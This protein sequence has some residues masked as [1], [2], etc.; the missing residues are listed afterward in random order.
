MKVDPMLAD[1]RPLPVGGEWLAE[2]KFDGERII[3]IK[4][5][6]K[7]E[8]WTRRGKEVAFK[9]PEV[10]EPLMA[11]QGDYI[12][13]GELTVQGGFTAVLNR[14]TTKPAMINFL[15]VKMPAT[16]HVFDVLS[17]GTTDYRNASLSERKIAL[18]LERTQFRNSVIPVIGTYVKSED[19]IDGL[20]AK[21]LTDGYEGLVIKN[22]ASRYREGARGADWVKM[23]KSDNFDCFVVGATRCTTN[24]FPFGSLILC[25]DGR[26]MGKVGTGF[27]LPTRNAIMA[28]L[29]ENQ[30]D[31][32]SAFV[33]MPNDVFK[34]V[35]ILTKP[36][37]CEIKAQELFKD[38]TPRHPVWV[39]WR[40]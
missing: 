32:Q 13:D 10:A 2:P 40:L 35:L 28:Y 4:E 21:A 30:A 19:E 33:S 26:Y 6:G 12:L 22:L 16:Y 31:R 37:P 15:R 39:R 5:N 9:F 38:G 18:A 23:K 8:M 1:A 11:I 17:V 34:E 7:L 25:K 29:K 27:D 20:M 3:A 14:A 24:T 36:L